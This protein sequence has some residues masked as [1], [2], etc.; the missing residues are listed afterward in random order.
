MNNVRGGYGF[1]PEE[2]EQVRV[3]FLHIPEDGYVE[4]CIISKSAYCAITHWIAGLRKPCLIDHCR[5]CAIGS[6]KMWRFWLEVIEIESRDKGII[7]LGDRQR[8][9]LEKELHLNR[10]R[11]L[12]IRLERVFKGK[13]A[14]I[15]IETK[16]TPRVESLPVESNIEELLFR[17]WGIK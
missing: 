13:N 17:I 10:L 7:E 2:L 3:N 6:V 15:N 8:V 16:K 12:T 4:F 5:G 1:I 9:W 14:P 11:G